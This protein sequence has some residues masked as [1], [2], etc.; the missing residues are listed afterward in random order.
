[1]VRVMESSILLE[2]MCKS[3]IISWSN[4]PILPEGVGEDLD[5]IVNFLKD[6]TNYSEAFISCCRLIEQLGLLTQLLAAS[7]YQDIPTID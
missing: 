5:I 4:A 2:Q 3:L 6:H 7:L 1:M